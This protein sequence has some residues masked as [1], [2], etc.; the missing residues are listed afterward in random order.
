[1]QRN[2]MIQQNRQMQMQP[3]QGVQ[4]VHYQNQ[5]QNYPK[6]SYAHPIQ[7]NQPTTIHY[8]NQYTQIPQGRQRPQKVYYE[9]YE[10]YPQ[11]KVERKV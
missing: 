11:N 5:P 4:R 8:E 10:T 2:N 6:F 9:D 7:Q 3:N 1:M